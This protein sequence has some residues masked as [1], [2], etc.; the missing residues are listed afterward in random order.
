M[1]PETRQ[2]LSEITDDEWR[3][4]Y[5]ELVLFAYARC[6]RWLWR[7][8]N[9]EN[10]P[11][12]NSPDSIVREAVT[13]L[14]DGTRIW[15][16]DQYP[17]TNPVPFLKSVVDSLIWALLSSA[18]HA[19][20]TQLVADGTGPRGDGLEQSFDCL[21]EGAGLR[22]S[23]ELPPDEKIYLEEIEGQ[24][25]AAIADRQDLEEYY[26]LLTEGL[27][28]AEIAVRMGTAV[29]RVYA[30]RKTFDRRTAEIQR[31]LFGTVAM[32]ER[33]AADGGR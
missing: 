32:G 23:S 8:G 21:E 29:K 15:N 11:E 10:L 22:Q 19:R 9:R 18:E 25:R 20:V 1:N 5:R 16:H 27:K 4:Y 26:E 30:L 31:E 2:I 17:G 33:A 13:R 24:I 14:Y 6:R 12:G 7:S 3:G 28:P